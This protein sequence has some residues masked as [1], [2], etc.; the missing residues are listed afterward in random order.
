[1]TIRDT[2]LTTF[3]A[4][5]DAI[6]DVS[7]ALRTTVNNVPNPVHCIVYPEGEDKSL[8]SHQQ[9]QCTFRVE[10][11]V[12]VREEDADATLDGGNAYRYLDRMVGE[13]EKVLHAPDS[14]GLDPDYTDMWTTGHVVEDPSDQ[15]ELMARVFVQF[16][17][18]HDYQ[19]PSA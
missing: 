10:V 11:L 7:A 6:T 14:W 16:Q 1:M 3:V 13:V 17:Y 9:Y 4:R 18:V 8:R 5:L 15:N 2:L 12:V 19:D